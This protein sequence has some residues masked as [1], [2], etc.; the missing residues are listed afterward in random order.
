VV[1]KAVD[2]IFACTYS[3]QL[4]KSTESIITNV[5]KFENTV[6]QEFELEQ[7][8]PN[9]FN[10]VTT[11]KFSLPKASVITLKVFDIAGR[12]VTELINNMNMNKGTFSYMFSAQDISSG[13][14]FYSLIAD[15][16]I[17]STK[18]MIIIK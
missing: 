17:A 1:M 14:Y 6:P 9:P 8:F 3:A 13:V 11:I 4:L 12:E 7:N 18:K 10:P 15:G 5:L 16:K 2:T